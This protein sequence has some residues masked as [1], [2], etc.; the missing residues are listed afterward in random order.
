MAIEKIEC[1]LL[2]ADLGDFTGLLYQAVTKHKKQEAKRSMAIVVEG[3]RRFFQNVFTVAQHS[4]NLEI[5]NTTGDGFLAMI[6][7]I[8]EN[9]PS[10]SMVAFASRVRQCFEKD[11]EPMLGQLP[12]RQAVN[13]RMALH[14]GDIYRIQ[15]SREENQ[16]SMYIGDDLN[17]AARVVN[18]QTARRDGIAITSDF[19]KRLMLLNKKSTKEPLP[20]D[21]EIIL[22]KN[23]Y[24]EQ[25]AVFRLPEKFPDYD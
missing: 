20:D 9:R 25:I 7:Q 24:P 4:K 5:I 2:F 8:P 16:H 11:T 18:S 15:I 1:S 19:Y 13:L 12:F 22:D 10:R 23:E 3:I 14:H 6:Q 21:V 17:L